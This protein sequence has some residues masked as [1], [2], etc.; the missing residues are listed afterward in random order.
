MRI[1][2]D[3]SLA[4]DPT[5]TGVRAPKKVAAATYI[6]TRM[7]GMMGWTEFD[8]KMKDDFIYFSGITHD[9]DTCFAFIK[10]LRQQQ[11]VKGFREKHC[12]LLLSILAGRDYGL[13]VFTFLWKCPGQRR[14]SARVKCKIGIKS[15]HAI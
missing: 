14:A 10:Q 3:K 5:F 12:P 4:D 11:S 6:Y 13:G 7:Q 8:M 15:F 1:K 9:A 2:V